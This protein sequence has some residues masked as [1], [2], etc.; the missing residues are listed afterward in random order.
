MKMTSVSVPDDAPRIETGLIQFGKDWPG[1]FIRGDDS[2]FFAGN[3]RALLEH[4]PSSEFS[5]SILRSLLEI[6]ESTDVRKHP[7]YMPSQ[8]ELNTPAPKP[9]LLS[10][11]AQD[12]ARFS[13][14]ERAPDASSL[15]GSSIAEDIARSA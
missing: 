6:L 10:Q 3:L 5:A 14:G 1:A 7:G 15:P 11:L 2:F 8:A 4:G 9:P 12:V 13:P